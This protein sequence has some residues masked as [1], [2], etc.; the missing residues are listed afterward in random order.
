MSQDEQDLLLGKACRE[1]NETEKQIALIDGELNGFSEGLTTLMGNP[2][3]KNRPN[4]V[5]SMPS[6]LVV[7]PP[8]SR[9]ADFSKLED[10]LEKK[11]TLIRKRDQLAA[12][13]KTVIGE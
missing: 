3:L 6:A 4:F 1:R 8:V 10:L 12:T 5:P 13:I 2:D 7:P 9:Y 11:R